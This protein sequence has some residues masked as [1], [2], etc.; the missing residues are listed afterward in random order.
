VSW[1]E[2]E[3]VAG[4]RQSA[5]IVELAGRLGLPIR[6]E[7]AYYK[8]VCPNPDHPDWE[9]DGGSCMLRPE[10][11][12]FY[13]FGCRK[14]GSVFTFYC[15]V[16]G[17]DP[18]RREDWLRA[19]AEVHDLFGMQLLAE[20]HRRAE[21]SVRVT[22]AERLATLPETTPLLEVPQGEYWKV[23][24]PGLLR[25]LTPQERSCF[26]NL[27][28]FASDV[29][30][31]LTLTYLPELDVLSLNEGNGRVCGVFTQHS[32]DRLFVRQKNTGVRMAGPAFVGKP[33]EPD[34]PRFFLARV[35]V[36][37]P[38]DYQVVAGAARPVV[39]GIWGGGC[40]RPTLFSDGF[41][42]WIALHLGA[43]P[44]SPRRFLATLADD[45]LWLPRSF[46]APGVDSLVWLK[47]QQLEDFLVQVFT[48]NEAVPF[49][50]GPPATQ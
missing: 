17:W 1:I 35:A 14:S 24:G 36:E 45:Q 20:Y 40:P 15:L 4:I 13:C 32:R 42:C 6:R 22:L 39:W 49:L 21:G 28:A 25:Y 3:V 41:H 12:S 18:G 19:V 37:N 7:G 48:A 8:T 16:K 26:F 38:L 46:R 50:H 34:A 31:P 10:N 30:Y 29:K 5:D 23:G 9:G 11:G 44:D 43:K 33:V 2:P 47:P 27:R